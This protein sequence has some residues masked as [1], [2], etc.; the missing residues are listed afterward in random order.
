MGG[1]RLVVLS[2]RSSSASVFGDA[3]QGFR[4]YQAKVKA[5]ASK[6]TRRQA[7]EFA[8]LFHVA[9]TLLAITVLNDSELHLDT[10]DVKV[11]LRSDGF[12]GVTW[13]VARDTLHNQLLR[14]WP[15]SNLE[16]L[17]RYDRLHR[18][19]FFPSNYASGLSSGPQ[20]SDFPA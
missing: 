5:R 19:F 9:P 14:E 15:A 18:Q 1:G 10:A 4:S 16:Q 7:Q 8:Q 3:H 13:L 11:V 12:G 6:Q 17:F 20:L 2:E